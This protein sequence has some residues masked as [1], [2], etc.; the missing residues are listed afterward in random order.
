ML[1][2][3][4]QFSVLRVFE[5]CLPKTVNKLISS[6]SGHWSDACRHQGSRNS[7]FMISKFINQ[8][9]FVNTSSRS[10]DVTIENDR[11]C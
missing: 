9:Y 1:I 6:I 5:L 8:K 7:I 2:Y 11:C 4:F 10:I 3:G